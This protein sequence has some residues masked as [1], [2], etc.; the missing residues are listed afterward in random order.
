MVTVQPGQNLS[1]I[2]AKYKVSTA[3]LRRW[4][5]L[6]NDHIQIGQKLRV[7]AP[8]R[9]HTVKAGENLG[10]I[11]AKYKV[12]AK[13]LMRTNKLANPDVLPV[14]KDLIIP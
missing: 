8:V 14:G 12:S 7:K 5:T 9:V 4:N 13:V 3:D 11:A 2:A 10:G 1:A 6:K